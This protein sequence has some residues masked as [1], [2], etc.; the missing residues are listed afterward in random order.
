VIILSTKLREGKLFSGGYFEVLFFL[1]ENIRNDTSIITEGQCIRNTG[2]IRALICSDCAD[3]KKVYS[4]V[5]H[6]HCQEKPSL[7]K[8]SP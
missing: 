8:Y 6:N 1:L 5:T 4:L 2:V 7:G 3:D